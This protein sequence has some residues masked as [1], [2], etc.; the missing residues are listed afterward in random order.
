[1]RILPT[2]LAAA[3]ALAGTA[4][5]TTPASART[6][7]AVGIGAPAY[8]A[9]YPGYYPGY[10]SPAYYPP[11]GVVVGGGWYGHRYWGRPYGWYGRGGRAYRGHWHR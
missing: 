1:M 5:A 4:V 6:V 3:A 8:P 2:A 7:V 10:Y 11:Y 9:Y